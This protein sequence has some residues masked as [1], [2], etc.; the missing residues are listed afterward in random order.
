[1]SDPKVCAD[2]PAPGP[3]LAEPA[4]PGGAL[5]PRELPDLATR[6]QEAQRQA[7]QRR[8]EQGLPAQADDGGYLPRKARKHA[9]KRSK[10][11]GQFLGTVADSWEATRR[12][13]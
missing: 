10:N 13:T 12:R 1:M 11:H 2:D 9:A 4:P 5:A 8:V 3:S 6:I 7:R